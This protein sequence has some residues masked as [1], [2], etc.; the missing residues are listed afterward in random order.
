MTLKETTLKN[1]SDSDDPPGK[2]IDFMISKAVTL[3]D[4]QISFEDL[5]FEPGLLYLNKPETPI[6]VIR[7]P[8]SKI[9]IQYN[10]D[11]EVICKAECFPKPTYEYYN[12]GIKVGDGPIFKKSNATEKDAGSY[13]CH[14]IQ[15]R[16]RE[17]FKEVIKFEVHIS[18]GNF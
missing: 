2:A 15:K 3:R 14:I 6:K 13:E 11:F 9:N 7:F 4:I 18:Q 8:T 16:S 1:Y 17:I 5:D 10:C 12:N